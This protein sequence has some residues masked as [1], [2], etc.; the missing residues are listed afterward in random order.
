MVG[1]VDRA[2][3]GAILGARHVQKQVWCNVME[4][5]FA[6]YVTWPLNARDSSQLSRA[7]LRNLPQLQ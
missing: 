2:R 4:C 5:I 1:T 6:G 3:H 7:V